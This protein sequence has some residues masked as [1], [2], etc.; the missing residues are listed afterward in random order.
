[1]ITN[2]RKRFLKQERK[3]LSKII[4]TIPVRFEI[5]AEGKKMIREGI[6]QDY[7]RLKETIDAANTKIMAEKT[8]RNS[9]QKIIGQMCDFI[10]KH[11]KDLKQFEEQMSS[12]DKELEEVEVTKISRIEAARSYKMLVENLLKK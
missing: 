1:M 7:D 2:P 12:L 10:A 8:K 4:E 9:D 3:R 6:R 11:E 5:I